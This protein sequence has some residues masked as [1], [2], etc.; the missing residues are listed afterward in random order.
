MWNRGG[1]AYF[2]LAIRDGAGEVSGVE[3]DQT[4]HRHVRLAISGLRIRA[5]DYWLS[6]LSR[7]PHCPI[8]RCSIYLD[9]CYPKSVQ[10]R[11]MASK[12]TRS[13]W[14]Q[15]PIAGTRFWSYPDPFRR[16]KPEVVARRAAF[17]KLWL[18]NYCRGWSGGRF[19]AV[20]VSSLHSRRRGQPMK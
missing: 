8:P 7:V 14:R 6:L 15:M 17:G 18:F 3:I 1:T 12:H 20:F 10:R 16:H 4:Q 9:P 19:C 2:Q 11:S 13:N 5:C